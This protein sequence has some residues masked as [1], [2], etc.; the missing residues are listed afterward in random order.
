VRILLAYVVVTA[1]SCVSNH[2]VPSDVHKL[3]VGEA[4]S[5]PDEGTSLRLLE[6]DA[7]TNRAKFELERP[8]TER[9]AVWISKADV[10]KFP[11][12]SDAVGLRNVGDSMVTLICFGAHK[13]RETSAPTRYKD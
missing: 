9:C 11:G 5:V 10:W 3:R 1:V 2:P 6:I 7:S 8:D 4:V 13:R 12:F